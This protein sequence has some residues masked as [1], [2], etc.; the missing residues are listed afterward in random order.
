MNLK[1]SENCLIQSNLRIERHIIAG[2]DSSAM[3]SPNLEELDCPKHSSTFS[4]V[5][6]LFTV[7]FPTF[8]KLPFSSVMNR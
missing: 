8:K 7:R 2:V 3:S 4:S 1:F 6:N 5:F